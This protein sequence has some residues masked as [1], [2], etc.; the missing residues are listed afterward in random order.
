MRV[1]SPGPQPTSDPD[2]LPQPWERPLLPLPWLRG[3]EGQP[4]SPS[5]TRAN[6]SLPSI[7]GPPL[8]PQLLHCHQPGRQPP[9]KAVCPDKGS[10]SYHLSEGRDKVKDRTLGR[11]LDCLK[12]NTEF[13]WLLTA[14]FGGLDQAGAQT[15][16]QGG[17]SQPVSSGLAGHTL[18]GCVCP[19]AL[20][21]SEKKNFSS[22]TVSTK[23]T[24]PTAPTPTNCTICPPAN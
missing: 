2:C 13:I 7:S 15:A 18:S 19:T 14:T 3:G 16:S 24:G 9:Q 20:K 22:P 23:T 21:S 5:R 4:L 12:Q 17:P 6:T 10:F 11:H 8:Q 1:R